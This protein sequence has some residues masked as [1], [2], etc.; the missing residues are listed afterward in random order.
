MQTESSKDVERKLLENLNAAAEEEKKKAGEPE[1]EEV[2]EVGVKK[3]RRLFL[4]SRR[5]AP[6]YK[7]GEIVEVAGTKYRVQRDGWR[8]IDG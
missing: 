8:R 7:D 3:A 5:P 6:R 2:P 4:R 1:K